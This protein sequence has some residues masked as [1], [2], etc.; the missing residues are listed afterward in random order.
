MRTV[1][2]IELDLT[3]YQKIMLPGRVK[4]LH[5]GEQD[6]KLM[7]WF[8][9]ETDLADKVYLIGIHGTGHPIDQYEEYIGSV[10]MGQFVWHVYEEKGP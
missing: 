3:D 8:E 10:Q 1:W 5:V 2:K 7:L 9:C 4:F 6:D